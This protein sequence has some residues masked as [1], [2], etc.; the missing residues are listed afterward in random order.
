MMGSMGGFGGFGA[1]GVAGLVLGI[2]A[3]VKAQNLKKEF[4]I[5]KE[6]IKESKEKKK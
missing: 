4:E 2:I 5:L 1:F 6:S 3:L